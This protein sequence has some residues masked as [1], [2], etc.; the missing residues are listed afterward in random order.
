[1]ANIVVLVS[2]TVY[3]LVLTNILQ[4]TLDVGIVTALNITIS[5]LVTICILAQPITSP[6]PVPAPLAVL[7]F[8]PELLARDARAGAMKLFKTTLGATFFLA[9]AITIVLFFSPSIVIP[10][11]GGQAVL[12]AYIQLSAID[13]LVQ[14]LAQVSLGTLIA[15]GDMKRATFYIVLWSVTRYASASILLVPYAIIGVLLGFIIGDAILLLTIV[16]RLRRS[17]GPNVGVSTF[18]L[19]DLT[20]YSMYTL[21]SALIGFAITQADK[22]FALAQQ[23]LPELAIYNVAIVAAS[24][25]GFAPYALIT[26]LLPAFSTLHASNKVQQ[27]RDMIRSY[28]RYVSLAVIP[29][30]IGFAS[31]TEVALRIFGASYTS[32]LLPSVIV[33]VATGLT[34]IGAVYAGALLAI[35]QLRWYTGANV[36]GLLGLFLTS[37]LLT[38]IVGLSG[39]ALGRASL[40]SI[41]T[42]VYAIGIRRSG[43]FQLDMR[44]LLSA[45]GG[46]AIMGVVVFFILTS[47]HSFLVKLAILPVLIMLGAAIYLGSLRLLHL[48]T[49][50][51]V[52][53]VRGIAPVRLHSIIGKLA[54][55]VGIRGPQQSGH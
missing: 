53:F 27:M 15:A 21:F 32:G 12:P 33:S 7:K 45:V 48:L 31:I 28:T 3:F 23:G 29:I 17:L 14:S 11:I 47:F 1:M 37:A 19:V 8:L 41:A 30:A 34:A 20:R 43:F 50:D 42:L 40:M 54:K 39:P 5:L 2:N 24:I 52:E 51:D 26:V 4:S 38:P 46:S 55:I 49:A 44:A 9:G 25:A 16:Q 18:S 36:L 6:S 13:V 22:I 35:G 10:L